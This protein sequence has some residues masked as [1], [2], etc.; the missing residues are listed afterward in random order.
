MTIYN[1][2]YTY[3]IGWSAHKTYYYGVRYSKNITEGELW[4]KYFT[5]SKFVAE[6]RETHGEP[7]IIEKRRE[8]TDAQ[9]AIAWEEKTLRRIRACQRDDFINRWNNRSYS[10]E[11]IKR[12]QPSPEHIEKNRQAHLGK[13]LSNEHKS[14][15]S[16]TMKG[17]TPSEEHKQKVSKAMKGKKQRLG[18]KNTAEHNLK[19]S[20]AMKESWARRKA[21]RLMVRMEKV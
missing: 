19:V 4:T 8:F 6:F 11:G 21:E 5:S 3:L 15:I 7:D 10:W 18:H 2:P 9:S 1:P 12:G 16:E 13:P 17:Y 14:K 20:V